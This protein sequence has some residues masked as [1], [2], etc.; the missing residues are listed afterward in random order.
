MTIEKT[1]GKVERSNEG[2]QRKN[3]P[4]YNPTGALDRGERRMEKALS[5]GSNPP[6]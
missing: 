2:Q 5:Y 4:R 6:W 1:K 3:G